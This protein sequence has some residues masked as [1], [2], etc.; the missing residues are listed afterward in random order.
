MVS[1]MPHEKGYQRV[2][3]TWKT[4]EEDHL[5]TKTV[6]PT[7]GAGEDEEEYDPIDAIT[8]RLSSKRRTLHFTLTVRDHF[9]TRGGTDVDTMVSRSTFREHMQPA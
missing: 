5:A 2:F 9:S 7:W 3:P 6:I 8:E 4:L 1:V